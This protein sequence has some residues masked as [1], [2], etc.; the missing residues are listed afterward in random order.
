MHFDAEARDVTV[1]L[2]VDV[3]LVVVVL[4]T[5]PDVAVVPFTVP[6]EVDVVAIVR[7]VVTVVAT[8]APAAAAAAGARLRTKVPLYRCIAKLEEAV[9]MSV[10]AVA[11]VAYMQLMEVT[12][13]KGVDG[14]SKENAS[15]LFW[16][17]SAFDKDSTV[18]CLNETN[19]LRIFQILKLCRLTTYVGIAWAPVNIRA[20]ICAFEVASA[21]PT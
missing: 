21:Q 18:L 3:V 9:L 8:F 15:T 6:D 10:G 16:T 19:G 5:V 17:A 1:V 4:P 11:E 7:W 2:A 12:P 14:M 20:L 13:V